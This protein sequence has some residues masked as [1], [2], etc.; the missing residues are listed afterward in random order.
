MDI[1]FNYDIPDFDFGGDASFSGPQF[2]NGSGGFR[3][4]GSGTLAMLHGR[5]AVV[6]ESQASAVAAGQSEA[7]EALLQEVT[8]LRREIANLPIHLRD[9]ILMAR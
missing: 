5:E 7:D 8:G 4:F 9:A 1:R 2:A 3:D 6:P